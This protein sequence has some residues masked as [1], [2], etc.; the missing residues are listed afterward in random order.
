MP[1]WLAWFTGVRDLTHDEQG[2]TL[3]FSV[4]L[5]AWGWALV[6]A[7][8]VLAA[9][10]SYRRL[11]GPAWARAGLGGVRAAL[12][13]LLVLLLCG[14]KLS[15]TSETVE[16]DWALLL[17]DRSSSMSIAD[18]PGEGGRRISR[19]AQ[20][21]AMLNTHEASLSA[22]A[23]QRVAAWIGFD[24]GAYELPRAAAEPG[25][26]IVLM[27][28][29]G[30]QSNLGAAIE[31]ALD[32]AAA[33]PISGVVVFSDGQSTDKV[34]R[35]LIRRLQAQRI[36]V[37]VV[38]LGSARPLADL[39]IASVEGPGVAF[40]RDTVPIEAVVELNGPRE[41]SQGLR[42][43]AQLID[44]ATG[45]VLDEQ[46]VTL[47]EAVEDR[48]SARVKLA[49]RPSTPGRAQWAV[50]LV[51]S[52]GD[53][54]RPP[55]DKAVPALEFIDRPLRV[56]YIDGYP[57]WEYRYLKNLLARERSISFAALLLAP[58]R[59]YLQEG[60][61]TID[62][63]PATTKE[64]QQFDV[65]VLGDVRPEV[66]SRAQLD[67]LR[68]RVAV[69]GAGL[70]WIAG[71]GPTPGAWRG[72]PLADLIPF[73]VPGETGQA[74]VW[75][76]DVTVRPTALAQSLGVLRLADAPDERGSFWPPAVSD[77]ATGWS[78]LRW[79]QRLD[80]SMLKPASEVLAE[81]VG[82]SSQAES[83]A[84]VTTMRFG[85]GRVIYVG[86]DEVWRWRYGRGEDLPE[87]F[88]LQLVRLLGRD[89][90]ARSGKP[91]II[92]ITP[93]RSTV[94][95]AVGVSVQLI[96]QSLVDGGRQAVTVRVERIGPLEGSTDDDAG[97]GALTPPVEL[98]LRLS[99]A[100]GAEQ[101]WYTGTWVP[102]H[103]GRY[104]ATL[105]DAA[106]L[107]PV[108]GTAEAQ[109]PSADAEVFFPDDELRRPQ[110]N[111]AL[112]ADLANETGGQVLSASDLDRLDDLLPRREVRLP[113]TGQERTL[114]DTPLALFLLLLLL[115]A[116]WVGRRLIRLV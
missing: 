110:T 105:A 11:Q 52:G 82:V 65:I 25:K 20:L 94:G 53:L 98:T 78:R 16:R 115:T 83:A 18:A 24:T 14:P 79:A 66:F 70:L 1:D 32:K 26:P 86:T 41:P 107:G 73:V 60:T 109:P 106:L 43:R 99:T 92:E 93:A 75:R 17:T 113:G 9:M 34:S 31:H 100:S 84:L 59:R 77:P 2:V 12:L 22:L 36:G 6:L 7:G 64:W 10:W 97:E 72:T 112:L 19:D 61:Q 50:R 88:W 27:R 47:S 62:S 46:P 42:V 81:A 114:W 35:S 111:H 29:S 58:G 104:R 69:G 95:Q 28:P 87:R 8:A 101:G 39:S 3:T 116:E 44:T 76:E 102:T 23:R 55:A 45:A 71:Q 51:S 103:T 89:A 5:P 48:R 56:L 74:P 33:R 85:S 108:A 37:H 80:R 57:R 13:V 49:S 30:R 21:R 67:E 90:V 96:D 4:P 54:L 91:A 38:P 15:R 63:V 68:A 40:L